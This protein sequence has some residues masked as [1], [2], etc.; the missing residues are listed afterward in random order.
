MW[1]KRFTETLTEELKFTG[2]SCA[3]LSEITNFDFLEKTLSENLKV[4]ISNLQ[5]GFKSINDMKMDKCRKKPDELL[6]DHL[7]QCCWAQCPFCKAICTNT[8]ENHHGEHSVPFHRNIGLNGWF[9]RGTTN[10]SIS[11]CTSAVASDQSF[12][13]D[14]SENTVP[15]K[16]YRKGGAEYANWSI[17][18]DL[19]ELPYWKWFVCRFQKDLE[20]HYNKTFEGQGVIPN[21]WREHSKDKAIQSLDEYI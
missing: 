1:Q 13:P 9:Y 14:S 15:W 8:I 4:I 5:N 17:T 10:L 6:I 12:Y 19:S 21:E 11:I 2:N 18:P 16:E 20:K 7:C 3:D